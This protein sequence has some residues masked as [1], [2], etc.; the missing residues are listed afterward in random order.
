MLTNF[1]PIPTLKTV[2]N[3]F[4]LEMQQTKENLLNIQQLQLLLDKIHQTNE[5]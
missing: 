2:R 3:L 4:S 5:P 1:I